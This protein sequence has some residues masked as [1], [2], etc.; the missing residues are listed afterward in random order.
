[1]K[2]ENPYVPIF[3]HLF[4]NRMKSEVN[5]AK[6]S[7]SGVLSGGMLTPRPDEAIVRRNSA[8]RFVGA[9]SE[10]SRKTR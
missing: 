2:D 4:K 9:T 10:R 5:H 3:V 1:V 6:L 7:Q 8:G